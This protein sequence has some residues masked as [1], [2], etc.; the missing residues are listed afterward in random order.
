MK[1]VTVQNVAVNSDV[2]ADSG[3]LLLYWFRQ[4]LRL[5]DNPALCAALSPTQRLLPV[6]CHLPTQRTTQEQAD[7][8]L[9]QPLSPLRQHWL[10]QNLDA[11]RAE[12]RAR[13]SDLLELCGWPEQLLPRLAQRLQCAEIHCAYSAAPW[14]WRV[15]QALLHA[16][17]RLRRCWQSGLFEPETLPFSLRAMPGHFTPFRQQLEAHAL[18]VLR[19]PAPLQM[20]PLPADWHAQLADDA[21]L[22]AAQMAVAALPLATGPHNPCSSFPLGTPGW[23]GGSKAARQHL[24]LYLHSSLLPAYR[25]TRNQLF[26]TEFSS[27]LSPWLACG[28]LSAGDVA[29]ALLALRQ[30]HGD[31]EGRQWL[32]QEILWREFFHLRAL[33][34]PRRLFARA[35]AAARLNHRSQGQRHDPERLRAWCEARSGQALVDAGMQELRATGYLSNRMRQ[36]VASHCVHEL[37]CR[38]DAGAA[39]F[40]QQLLDFDVCVNSGNWLYLAG[41]GADPRGGRHFD[42]AYQADK[43]DAQGVYRRLWG[44][45]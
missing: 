28:A 40:E 41:L 6:Y 29:A 10:R 2:P 34:E 33:A 42:L 1:Y 5:H 16:G 7:A 4:D 36:I 39:W 21:V 20:P 26:G 19:H 13:G 17:L 38:W 18:S 15:E 9:P 22:Q 25:Q 27:K 45:Q 8:W 30:E 14:E 31:S 37:G 24:Q 32:W 3:P 43:H 12:L 44:Q 23:E 35:G 11:L